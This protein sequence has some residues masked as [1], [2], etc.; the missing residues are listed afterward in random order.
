MQKY[1]IVGLG[2]IGE[3][4]QHTRHNIGFM[5]A[6][7]LAQKVEQKFK[8]S[9][10]GEIIQFKYKG[11]PVTVLKP[12]TYM[13]LSGR[14][15]SFWAKKENIPVENILV[16]TDDLNLP[17]GTLRMRG[18]GSD[19]GHN[20]LKNIQAE[21]GT[22][23]YPKLRFGIGDKFVRGAQIDYVLGEWSAQEQEQMAERLDKASDACLSF[24]FAGLANTMNT[25]NGK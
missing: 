8:P 1:L 3:E 7:A 5:V 15:V 20:G 21:L 9:N 24:V 22:T 13:N 6:D 11:R 17:F 18:K 10:F 23:Q 16:V 19:G 25:F 12:N 14:A 2:N 4:Y